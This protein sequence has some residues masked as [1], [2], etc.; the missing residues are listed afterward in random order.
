MNVA[1][2]ETLCTHEVSKQKSLRIRPAKQ[3]PRPLPRKANLH[4]A[5]TQVVC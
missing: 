5:S 3:L 1:E 2:A 4:R